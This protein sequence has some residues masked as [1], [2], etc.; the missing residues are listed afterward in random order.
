MYHLMVLGN[1]DYGLCGKI[2][3][4]NGLEYFRTMHVDLRWW[5]TQQYQYRMLNHHIISSPVYPIE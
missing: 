3:L 5:H 2:N 1:R 4:K